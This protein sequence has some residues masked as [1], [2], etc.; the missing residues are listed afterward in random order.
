MRDVIDAIESLIFELDSLIKDLQRSIDGAPSGSLVIKTSKSGVHYYRN[1]SE[2]ETKGECLEYL[3]K[4]KEPVVKALSQKRYDKGLLKVAVKQKAELERTLARMEQGRVPKS[5]D[6]VM[7]TIPEPLRRYIVPNE[8][9]N[10]GFIRKWSAPAPRSMKKDNASRDGLYTMKGEHVRSKSELLIA[11]RLS[12]KDVP[13]H[14][15]LAYSPDEGTTIIHPDFT[16]LNTRT[17]EQF[18]WE[19]LGKMDDGEY[20]SMAKKRIERYAM[21]GIV[22]GRNLIVTFE[23]SGNPIDTRYIDKLIDIYLK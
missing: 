19:H 6:E 20:A 5:L 8:R 3:G 7:S 13:Y 2:I 10:D 17:C 12:A 23:T 18:F 14:Y 9:T 22:P 21:F 1:D 11:D 15:E 16:V 4:G